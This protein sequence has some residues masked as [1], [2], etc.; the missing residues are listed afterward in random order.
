MANYIGCDLGGTNMRAA[1]VNSE[2]GAVSN[3]EVVPTLG[4][5]GPEGVLARMVNL[6]ATIIGKAKLSMEENSRH[7]RRISGNAR[8]GAWHDDVYY[9]PAGA[10]D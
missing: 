6:F 3:L 7:W 5:E 1:I 10:L 9:Q 2:T 4:R 8:H